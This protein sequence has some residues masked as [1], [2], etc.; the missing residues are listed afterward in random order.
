MK[1][2]KKYC[3]LFF[4]FSFSYCDLPIIHLTPPSIGPDFI[5]EDHACDRPMR[6]NCFQLK[7]EIKDNKLLV[8]NYGAGGAGW[9]FSFG[10]VRESIAHFENNLK[11]H[12]EFQNNPIHIIGAGVMG[13]MSALFLH[14]K[15]YKVKIS[16]KELFDIPSYN[17]AGMF[18]PVAM[19]TNTENLE[20][21]NEIGAQSFREWNSVAQG[22]HQLFKSG[23][24]IMPVFVG[25]DTDVGLDPYVSRGLIPAPQEVLVNFDATQHHMRTY[26]TLFIDTKF[27]MESLH[28]RIKEMN[29]SIEQREIHAFSEIKESIIFN[30]TGLGARNLNND[31][32][33]MPVRGHLIYLKNQPIE[34]K[35]QYMLYTTVDSLDEAG[36]PIKECIYYAPKQSGILGGTF[37][38]E[39]DITRT[40]QQHV[41]RLMQR[42][43]TFFGTSAK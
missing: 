21:A 25:K 42:S 36:N 24:K 5:C 31:E 16:A 15:G 30:C 37:I 19:E 12:P 32:D 14:E 27:M 2:N 9:A 18:C 6:S 10:L 28:A 8:H 35:M 22:K 1:W 3:L 23:A 17:A 26:I 13:L 38:K 34:D 40:Q 20:R 29:I 39:K 43:C 33:M 11:L 4:V 7:A 41:A